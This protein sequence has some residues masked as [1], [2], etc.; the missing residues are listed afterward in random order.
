[1]W[2]SE[3]RELCAQ[4]TGRV[5]VR[6]ERINSQGYRSDGVYWYATGFNLSAL[7]SW[8]IG[9][10]TYEFIAVMKFAIGGSMPSILV[11]GLCYFILARLRMKSGSD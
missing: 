4:F 5:S 2:P 9:F 3:I 8:A 10:V 6:R 1:M 11:A 7:L